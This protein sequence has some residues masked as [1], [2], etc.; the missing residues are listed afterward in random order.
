MNDTMCVRRG[1]P[2]DRGQ[3]GSVGTV[4]NKVQG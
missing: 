3:E 1:A 2:R 4:G